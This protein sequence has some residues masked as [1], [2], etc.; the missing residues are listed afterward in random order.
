MYAVW[1]AFLEHVS[2]AKRPGSEHRYPDRVAQGDEVILFEPFFDQ[3]ISN[4]VFNEGVP[5]YVPLHPAPSEK[6]PKLID[7]HLD[8]DELRSVTLVVDGARLDSIHFP[9]AL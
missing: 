8:F 3:Y 5:V 6:N 1:A 2:P 4:I 9:A 7:W